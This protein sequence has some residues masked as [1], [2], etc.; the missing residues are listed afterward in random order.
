MGSRPHDLRGK[1]RKGDI[2]M[3]RGGEIKRRVEERVGEVM[4]FQSV[5]PFG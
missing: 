1:E 5:C 2:M 3:M 4:R